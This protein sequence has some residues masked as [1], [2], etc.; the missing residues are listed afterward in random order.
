[1]SSDSLQPDRPA[2][3]E[4]ELHAFLT[5]ALGAGPPPIREPA[6]PH[7]TE[8]RWAA[9]LGGAD[10]VAPSMIM[11]CH[12]SLSFAFK[13][14]PEM[15]PLHNR[16]SWHSSRQGR[17]P[18]RIEGRSMRSTSSLQFDCMQWLEIDPGTRAMCERPLRLQCRSGEAWRSHVP[19]LLVARETGL[20][21][22]DLA[23]ESNAG[24]PENEA[25]WRAVGTALGTLGIGYRI[26]TERHIRRQ[27]LRGNIATVFRARHVRVPREAAEAAAALIGAV[28]GLPA[29]ELT[30]Q[31]GLD[32]SQVW[33]LV[34]QG[35]LAV[36]LE[37]SPLG[38]ATRVSLRLS[39]GQR[40]GMGAM[41]CRFGS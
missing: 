25:R 5:Q 14:V 38:P 18:S 20:E 19:D 7:S 3:G 37:S 15:K 33:S 16:P 40:F 30:A 2:P 4:V 31:S 34:R 23:Y 41:A 26:L 22:I 9:A 36:D 8:R 1:M 12:P 29:H 11:A 39:P 35:L 13:G 21:C 10:S 24:L 32:A 28:P 27:P 6:P 17:M